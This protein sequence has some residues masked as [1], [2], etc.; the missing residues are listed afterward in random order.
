M[1]GLKGDGGSS[2]SK[3]QHQEAMVADPGGPAVASLGRAG[4]DQLP[5]PQME[6]QRS[7]GTC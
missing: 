2:W 3:A 6:T 4:Q 7:G 5:T 1:P